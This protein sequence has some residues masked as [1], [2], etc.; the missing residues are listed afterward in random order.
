MIGISSR[1]AIADVPTLTVTELVE[2]IEAAACHVLHLRRASLVRQGLEG[3]LTLGAAIRPESI[4]IPLEHGAILGQLGSTPVPAE[5]H[6]RFAQQV[7]AVL[8]I[9]DYA[10]A[11][12]KRETVLAALLETAGQ[13]TACLDADTVLQTIVARARSLFDADLSYITTLDDDAG[14]V[15]MQVAVGH[16][17]SEF[18]NIILPL[19]AGLG[20]V[21]ART[22]R[23]AYSADYLADRELAH[24][25]RTDGAVR[26]EGIRSIL[27][28][29]LRGRSGVIGVLFVANRSVHTFKVDEIALLGSLGDHAAL[30]LENARLYSDAQNAAKA[31]ALAEK[32]AADH[33]HDLEYLATLQH[34]LTEGVLSGEGLDGL[35]RSVSSVI[36]GTAVV[37]DRRNVI[38]ASSGG[39][40]IGDVG[41]AVPRTRLRSAAFSSAL[42]RSRSSHLPED[43]GNGPGTLTAVTAGPEILGYL[44]CAVDSAAQRADV[45]SQFLCDAARVA[46]LEILRERSASQIEHRLRRDFLAEL[47]GSTIP[48]QASMGNWARQ[49][50]PGL[51]RSHRA[52]VARISSGGGLDTG[53]SMLEYARDVLL[54]TWPGGF[55]ATYGSNLVMFLPKTRRTDIAR[56]VQRGISDLSSHGLRGAF[57][58]GGIC[59]ALADDRETI[60]A[61]MRLQAFVE[62][63]GLLWLEGLELI[64]ALL[65]AG[66]E[67]RIRRYVESA[68]QPFASRDWII[69]TLA[70]YYRN[71]GNA[72]S[73]AKA[74]NL[75]PNSVRYRLNLARRMLGYSVDDPVASL[76]LRLAL[77]G[78]SISQSPPALSP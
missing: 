35:V 16:L 27:G 6:A 23:P 62:P 46:A 24:H 30:A 51:E 10:R 40:R 68:L 7:N 57:V 38:L 33:M 54:D 34:H 20:G 37:F 66:E 2:E 21:V 77:L 69:A 58:V 60:L 63:S 25:A 71:G 65:P 5:A 61:A 48:D 47:L 9:H 3:D 26:S 19:D 32:R 55:V 50:W 49:T 22:G 41:E 28:V 44:W 39:S 70:S 42:I 11:R 29:P 36:D 13:L 72:V 14:A 59:H 52:I 75:H 15:R 45:L 74:L 18:L 31:S 64:A 12:R 53:G 8:R 1:L 76:P 56:E 73:T 67:D 78:R 4:V 17:T 43:V